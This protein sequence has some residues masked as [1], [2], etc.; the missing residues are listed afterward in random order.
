MPNAV[1]DRAEIAV[2]LRYISPSQFE[3][4]SSLMKT[5]A[6]KTFV[7]GTKTTLT[8]TPGIP[9]MERTD[10]NE[11]L[12]DFVRRT[13]LE[14]GQQEPWAEFSGGGSDSAFSV[15]AGVPTL[16]QMG[17]RGEWN[18]S[19]REYAIVESIFERIALIVS[20]VRNI[21]SFLNGEDVSPCKT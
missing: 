13:A 3:T 5:I 1:P 11:R 20:S 2:D 14:I 7:D 17:V 15:Q 9:P 18:H 21:D 4:A 8:C 16:D 12:F 19:D 10:G 6:G